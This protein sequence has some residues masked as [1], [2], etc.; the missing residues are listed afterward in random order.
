[1]FAIYGDLRGNRKGIKGNEE[2]QKW[3]QSFLG[4]G[5]ATGYSE[6]F[7]RGRSKINGEK[8]ETIVEKELGKLNRGNV[9]KAA[10]VVFDWLSDYNDAM[11]NAVRLSAFKVYLE[12]NMSK[13]E[14]NALLNGGNITLDMQRHIDK[15]ASIA[16]NLTVNF[17]R[18]GSA[19]QLYQSLFAFFNASVQGTA[20]LAETLKGPA[21]RKIMAGGFALGAIQAIALA[22]AGY[23]DDEPPEYLKDKNL[24]IPLGDTYLIA[25]LPLGLNIFPGI[26][27]I[28]TEYVLGKMGF[29]TGAKGGA[30]KVGDVLALALDTFNP[31]G[32]GSLAQMMTPTIADPI[33]ALRTNKDAFGRPIS[34]EDM[35]SHPTPGYLRSR[36]NVNVIAQGIS[37]FL[38]Y[39]SGGNEDVK[40]GFSPTADQISYFA[41]QYTGGVGRELMKGVDFGSSLFTD[42]PLPSYR[43]PIVGKMY[44]ETSS[45]SAIQDKFYKN[46]VLM[47]EHEDSLKGRLKRHEDRQEYMQEHPEARLWKMANSIE[48]QISALNKQRK[49]LIESGAPDSKIENNRERKTHLMEKFNDKVKELQ[50]D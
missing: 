2:M 19:S 37:E 36:E 25:P 28:A 44:G 13:A 8:L 39:A 5:G 1:M 33:I 16:K 40:G 32:G 42:E 15:A 17:N 20:R 35:S 21:G 12:N 38:N 3:H 7:S 11:E 41:G 22:M 23:D 24:I 29:I 46:V 6:Q 30:S 48:N 26:G 45:P 27:R 18:K 14:I 49:Q 47:S 31:L 50:S 10:H 34:K 4:A 9:S 43:V